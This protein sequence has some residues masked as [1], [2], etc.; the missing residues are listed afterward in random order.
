MSIL[1]SQML[2]NIR[3]E[4]RPRAWVD[5]SHLESEPISNSDVAFNHSIT[6][7]DT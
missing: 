4:G 7:A 6:V 3:L 2:V 1:G 5:G